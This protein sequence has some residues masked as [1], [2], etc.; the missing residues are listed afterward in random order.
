VTIDQIIDVLE[1]FSMLKCD[2]LQWL[3]TGHSGVDK[4][5]LL[6]IEE[7]QHAARSEVETHK[8]EPNALTKSL[9]NQMINAAE[10]LRMRE[11]GRMRCEE[12]VFAH[13][14]DDQSPP[15]FDST[16]WC[17]KDHD[18]IWLS[19]I[20][21]SPATNQCPDYQEGKATIYPQR[22]EQIEVVI[23]DADD[24]S[25]IAI[26]EDEVYPKICAECRRLG[27]IARESGLPRVC[28]MED[29]KTSSG[30]YLKVYLQEWLKGYD[31][32]IG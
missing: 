2:V 29:Y 8:T 30:E 12:C 27:R 14:Y 3:A 22:D 19:G 24:Q 4:D 9:G 20:K 5:R 16:C 32:M 31:G 25:S 28:N 26:F 15:W 18:V 10:A 6:K 23:V 11:S 13:I 17:S 7:L 21:W 1:L